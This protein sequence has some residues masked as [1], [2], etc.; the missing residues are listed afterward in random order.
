MAGHRPEVIMLKLGNAAH[1]RRSVAGVCLL[2]APVLFAGAEIL[3]PESVGDPAG[4]L[5]DYAQHRGPLL[6]AALLGIAAT[7]FFLPAI[8][9]VLHV[10]RTRGVRFSHVGA[11][12]CVYGLVTAHAALS[13][14]NLAFYEMTSPNLSRP[15]M[16]KLLDDL[17]NAPA[18]GAPLVL[19]HLIFGV[20]VLLLGI[21]IWRSQAFPRWA[22]PCV[23]LWILVD[24]AA[25][26]LPVGHVVGDVASGAF[27]VLGFGTLGL[28]LLTSTD[29]SWDAAPSL[30]PA[31][32]SE[33]TL[34]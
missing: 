6:A 4:Q 34:A 21:G 31:L 3:A 16:V 8:F 27:A 10:I 13:G 30:E 17:T 23:A 15:E 32:L 24:V 5:A 7:I 12:M 26:S 33:R 11:A 1:F 22:G 19:G 14:V 25:S 2:V 29:A 28:T 18:I 20:G 9:G